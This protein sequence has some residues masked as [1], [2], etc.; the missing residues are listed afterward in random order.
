MKIANS[1]ARSAGATCACA[2]LVLAAYAQPEPGPIGEGQ[3]VVDVL[4]QFVTTLRPDS[5]VP[6]DILVNNNKQD[7]SGSLQLTL[8]N[9]DDRLSPIYRLPIDSPK[10]SRKRFR[11]YC[12]FKNA[13]SMSVMLYN[14]RRAALPDDIRLTLR[15]INPNDVL[16]LIL[17]DEPSDYGF[18]FNAVQEIGEGVGVHRE[19]LRTEE[20]SQLPEYPQCYEPYTLIV[21]GRIDPEAIPTRQ[22]ELL[23]RYVEH[24]GLLVVCLGENAPRYRGTWVEELAGAGIGEVQASDEAA[25]AARV[26]SPEWAGGAR[27]GKSILYAR[28]APQPGVYVP[29]SAA[30][31]TV[32]DREVAVVVRPIGSG[33]VAVV[34][35]DAAGKALQG[36][37][38]FVQVWRNLIAL[39]QETTELHYDHAASQAEYALPSATGIRVYPRSSVLIYLGLYFAIGIVGNWIFWSLFKRREMAWV[40]LI[41]ISFGFTAYAL[42]YGTA[43]R[44]KQTEIAQLEVVRLPKESPTARVRS[45]VGVVAARS[46]RY[47]LT[48]PNAFPLVS[49]IAGAPLMGMPMQDSLLDRVNAFHFVQ[50]P[51]STVE[52]L[53]VGASTMRLIQVDS[54]IASPGKIEGALTW[55]ADGIHGELTNATGLVIQAPFLVVNGKRFSVQQRDGV[56]VVNVPATSID[57][58]ELTTQSP[59]IRYGMYGMYGGDLLDVAQLREGFVSDLLTADAISGFS[60]ARIGPFVC[61]WVEGKPVRSID[62]GEPATERI[63]ATLLVADVDIDRLASAGGRQ[64]EITVS[65][66]P[67]NTL[68]L[69]QNYPGYYAN[70]GGGPQMYDISGNEPLEVLISLPRYLLAGAG[71]RIEVSVYWTANSGGSVVF[72]PK[73]APGVWADENLL[74]TT[75]TTSQGETIN[76]TTF[77]LKDWAERI[78]PKSGLLEGKLMLTKSGANPYA[79]AT[80]RAHIIESQTDSYG[81]D[82]KPWQS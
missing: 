55:D 11:M 70:Y 12:N 37:K 76:V 38:G 24:G 47:T 30:P 31:E 46:S 63:H 44:A 10:N 81:G 35:T 14:G 41:F 7:I 57:S 9:N 80:A 34:A 60:D 1:I 74:N 51:E 64:S 28:I 13:T 78:D 16:A 50:G 66:T 79:R 61:G 67:D 48:F 36:S 3:L 43:G 65:I 75:T 68:R 2:C 52:N 69:R 59:T 15:P 17:D 25:Y 5:W 27:E 53:T 42:V 21:L 62:I 71:G 4:P 49:D 72:S 32:A 6:V 40:C 18:L 45:T 54:E 26:F 29:A 82:W 8:L 23:R 56:W 19:S 33:H 73:D 77:A 58:R 39:R 20:L 22:R